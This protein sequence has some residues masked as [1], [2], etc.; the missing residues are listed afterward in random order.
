MILACRKP[1][2]IGTGWLKINPSAAV[3]L[4]QTEQIVNIG[5]QRHTIADQLSFQPH[6]RILIELC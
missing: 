5:A 2:A 1:H 3:E 4:W 6:S